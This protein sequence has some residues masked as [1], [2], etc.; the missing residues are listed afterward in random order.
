MNTK[1]EMVS[2]FVVP[3]LTAC[4]VRGANSFTSYYVKKWRTQ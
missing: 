2:S 3:K 4:I 1:V